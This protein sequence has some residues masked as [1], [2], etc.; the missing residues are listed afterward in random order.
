MSSASMTINFIPPSA[1]NSYAATLR[2]SA[3]PE[4]LSSSKVEV[5]LAF[6]GVFLPRFRARELIAE[7]TG[8]LL[9]LQGPRFSKPQRVDV[10]MH[11]WKGERLI[12]SWDI[13][14]YDQ[15]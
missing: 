12:E 9:I 3:L 13:D 15:M 6:N 14:A 2:L 5:S 10:K 11:A 1:G 8:Y 7:D 4:V